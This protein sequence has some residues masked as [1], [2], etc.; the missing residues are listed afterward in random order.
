MKKLLLGLMSVFALMACSD[1]DGIISGQ[2]SSKK[3]EPSTEVYVQGQSLTATSLRSTMA[4]YERMESE[5]Q[6]EK[7]WFYIRI[8]NRIP[9]MGEC[10]S[11]MYWPQERNG[12]STFSQL[13]AGTVD[14]TFPYYETNDIY[15]FYVYDTKGEATLPAIVDMP[16]LKDILAANRNDRFHLSEINTDTLKVIWYVVKKTYGKIHV[17]GVLTGKSTQDV[18]EVPGIEKDT[19]LINKDDTKL[20]P[21]SDGNVEVDIHQQEHKDWDEIK[22]TIH[23]RDLVDSVKVTIPI[24]RDNMAEADDFA[25]REYNYFYT[26]NNVPA[27][28]PVTV[29]VE[30]QD[31]KM[32]ITVVC[33]DEQYLQSLRETYK[34]GFTVEVHSYTK[35][36]EK[37]DV[38]AQLQQ[39]EVW[40]AKKTNLIFKGATS[41][42]FK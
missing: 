38:W 8:D 26:I 39:A 6:T 22:T 10:P 16:S 15:P 4:K 29:R 25:I 18:T 2:G 42:F 19:T 34:D 14:L 12:E 1:D 20:N 27:T 41:A 5:A 33:T 17:D 24:G 21:D 36:M 40:T 23:V 9:R 37:A 3:T 30:H 31:G 11:E 32:V 35:G 13:N 28:T 7:A